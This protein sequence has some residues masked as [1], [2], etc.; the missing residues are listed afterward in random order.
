MTAASDSITLQIDG[1]SC[2]TC[3]GRVESAAS[4]VDGV[5][6]ANVNLAADQVSV[7]FDVARTSPSEIAHAIERAGYGAS[8]LPSDREAE[9]RIAEE[10]RLRARHELVT[11]AIS[12]GLTLPLVAPMLAMPFGRALEVPGLWQLALATPVQL[13]AGARFYRGALGALRSRTANMDVLVALGTLAAYGL[14][15]FMLVR[16]DD[17]LY[18]EASASVITL[19]LLGKFFESRAKRSTGAA[20]RSLM[21]LRPERAR[22]LR[23]G[24][25]IDVPAEA[26]LRTEVVVI[27]PGE[28]IPVDGLIVRGHSE[29]DESM[30]TG[31]SMPVARAEGESVTGGS[32]NG[33]GL[34]HVEATRVGADSTLAHIVSLVADAQASKAPIQRTVDRVAAVFVPAVLLI[35]AATL[36]GWLFLGVSASEAIIHAVSVLVIACPCALGLATP[37]AL[38]VGTGAAARA[39]ILIKDAEALER[40]H[41]IDTVVF[42]KTGT[43]TEG[44]PEV[45]EIETLGVDEDALLS[46]VAAAQAGSEHPLGRAAIRAAEERGLAVPEL[47]EFESLAGR[48]ISAVVEDREVIVGSRRL[49]AERAIDCSALESRAEALE[50]EGRTVVWIAEPKA[51]ASPLGL[52][53]LGDRPRPGGAEAVATLKRLGVTVVMLTGDNRRTAEVVARELGIDEVIAEVLPEQKAEQIQKLSAQGRVVAMVGDGVNDAPAL[54]AADVGMAVSSGTDVA[55]H[56]ASVTLIRADPKLVADCIR[57]SRATTR[58]IWQNLF[59]AFVYNTAGLP[60][61]ALGF[62][63]PMFAGAAMAMSSVSVVSNSLVLRRWRPTRSDPRLVD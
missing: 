29:L 31:E 62:L 17:H 55:M 48:G 42:D 54:A 39:G 52:L 11:L 40:A 2:A 33:S 16:G 24:E 14:S 47:S 25:E 19:V 10:D 32:I 5:E 23:D 28:R 49:M 53:A 26:V 61:A 13:W 20:I 51:S 4:D 27:R 1:M 50:R 60:L 30:L 15:V 56:T 38:M 8:A 35:A 45:L 46:T 21:A 7:R 36:L 12:A 22:V 44:R 9:A 41:A 63:S 6:A 58:K 37:T 18:F 34:L 3:A 59:W 57:V 43:L